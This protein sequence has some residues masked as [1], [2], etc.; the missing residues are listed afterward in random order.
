MK[1]PK[2]KLKYAKGLG[3]II[4]SILHGKAIGWFTHFLTG[5]K[6]P[7]AACSQRAMALNILFPIPVWKLFFKNYEELQ[8]SFLKDLKDDG[9]EPLNEDKN[10]QV[11]IKNEIYPVTKKQIQKLNEQLESKIG[12][13]IKDKKL[14]N[15]SKTE[16][17][18][19]IVQVNIFQK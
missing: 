5:Q 15:T 14:I 12:Q 18:D 17:G 7:C 1:N 8:E 11:L 4:A 10:Q 3:D 19:Y 16:I 13:P 6:E 9:Y 2:F